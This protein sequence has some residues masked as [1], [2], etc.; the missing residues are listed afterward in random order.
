M[1]DLNQMFGLAKQA[2]YSNVGKTGHDMT[3]NREWASRPD[4]E[5]YT[6]MLALDEHLAA[7]RAASTEIQ[8]KVAAIRPDQHDGKL[9]F[10]IPG[11]NGLVE[12]THLGFS[13]LCSRIKAPADYL[14]RL[15][16]DLAAQCMTYG[17]D[18]SAVE[19]EEAIA[20]IT[21][22]E[23]GARLRATTS[24]GYGRI[25]DSELSGA[26]RKLAERN[27]DWQVPIAFLQPGDKYNPIVAMDVTKAATTLYSGDRDMFLFLVDQ[28][29]PI[30]AGKLP[31]GS[32]RL[33]FRGVM[34]WN[35]E[36]GVRRL[37]MKTFLYQMVC[38]NRQIHG[39]AAVEE[40]SQRHTKSAPEK[41]LRE[42]VPALEVY[43]NSTVTGIEAG[44]IKAQQTIVAR[45]D[46]QRLT[47]LER[48]LELGPGLSR[49]VMSTVEAEEGHPLETVFDAA[50]GLTAIA[51][52]IANQDRRV[53]LE[54]VAEDVMKPYLVA[55]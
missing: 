41:F 40:I 30:V 27:N 5:R 15:P 20:L 49:L 3:A 35:S 4:D 36:V 19:D 16:N 53:E 18:Q 43:M 31:D 13:Q 32:D 2:D 50:Q 11:Y 54:G 9:V 33:F 46:E 1:T 24:V 6:S 8:I 34:T 14:R 52:G 22:T 12:P 21:E 23:N 45:T 26:V 42:I 28:T 17:F 25:W 55:A 47:Y 29:R 7:Q 37:G 44:L 51:R 10:H 48:L 39:Q 38:Q